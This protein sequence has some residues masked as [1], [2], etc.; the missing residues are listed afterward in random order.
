[1]SELE[2]VVASRLEAEGRILAEA[3]AEHMLLCFH[4]QEPQ[5][6]LEPV[7]QGPAEQVSEATQVDVQETAKV[8]AERFD[9]QPEDA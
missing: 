7:V 2:D 9:R 8:V 5:V 1:M 4:S 6:S 3:V